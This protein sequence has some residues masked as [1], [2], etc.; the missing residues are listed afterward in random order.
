MNPHLERWLRFARE[1]L[2]M[3]ELAFEDGIH[4]QVCFHAHQAVEKT[5]KGCLEAQGQ[6]PPRTHKRADLI[7]M[8]RGSTL[9]DLE[10]QLLKVTTRI[11][12]ALSDMDRFYIPTRY[13]DA[14]P[15]MLPEGWPGEGDAREALELA[16]EVLRRITEERL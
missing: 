13:P 2:R 6:A 5:L 16:R 8:V 9:A 12:V 14:L 7:R 4:N 10:S 15:G 11:H 3:A 1:D